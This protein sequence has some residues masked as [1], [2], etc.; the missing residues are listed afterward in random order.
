[1]NK[2]V[3]ILS[4]LVLSAC[5]HSNITPDHNNNQTDTQVETNQSFPYPLVKWNNQVYQITSDFVDINNVD[6]EIGEIVN[7]SL[8]EADETPD[9]F[10]NYYSKGT[11]IFSIIKVDTKEAIAIETG[12]NKY[13]KAVISSP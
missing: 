9:N 8:D 11:K 10:S 2:V 1:M 6:K 3:I 7:V 13:V 4:F 12:Q 5:S